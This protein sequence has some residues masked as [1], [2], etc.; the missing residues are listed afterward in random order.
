MSIEPIRPELI[1]PKNPKPKPDVQ[2]ERHGKGGVK[3]TVIYTDESKIAAEMQT[4]PSPREM[5]KLA[6]LVA[7][8]AAKDILLGRLEFRNAGEASKVARDFAAIAKDFTW[9]DEAERLL[10]AD[11]AED[12][13]DSLLSFRQRAQEAL[14]QAD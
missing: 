13:K 9:D 10:Q 12:R 14:G 11:S 6:A 4:L 8:R 2:I 1:V 3:N 7:A 5:Q